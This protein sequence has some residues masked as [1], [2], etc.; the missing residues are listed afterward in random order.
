VL[1]PHLLPYSALGPAGRADLATIAGWAARSL[2]PLGATVKPRTYDV[3]EVL[4]AI[5]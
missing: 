5:S 3:R 2:A 1:A 4:Y